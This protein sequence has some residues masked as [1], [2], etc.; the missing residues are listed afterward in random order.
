VVKAGE[1]QGHAKSTYSGGGR[2]REGREERRAP[3]FFYMKI[4]TQKGVKGGTGGMI[5]KWGKAPVSQ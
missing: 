5:D 1:S 2:S 4:T 3:K